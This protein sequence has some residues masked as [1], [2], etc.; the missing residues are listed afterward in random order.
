MLIFFSR[1]N[2]IILLVAHFFSVN[3]RPNLL[4]ALNLAMRR[5]LFTFTHAFA[6]GITCACNRISCKAQ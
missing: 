5:V 6:P 2:T 4:F 3:G 1:S